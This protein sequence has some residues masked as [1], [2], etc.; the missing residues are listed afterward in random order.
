VHQGDADDGYIEASTLHSWFVTA[1]SSLG[2]DAGSIYC[3]LG[4]EMRDKKR[5]EEGK[6]IGREMEGV[7]G[8]WREMA[9]W[10]G[11]GGSGWEMERVGMKEREGHEN[12]IVFD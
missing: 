12:R 11:S 2:W 10:R 7:G 1:N 5:A 6:K 3:K 9:E 8:K 4:R